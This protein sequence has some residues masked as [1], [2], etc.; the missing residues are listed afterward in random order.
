MRMYK[1]VNQR[2]ADGSIVL[3]HLALT[4]VTIKVAMLNPNK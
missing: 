1:K 4:Q 2:L 3:D